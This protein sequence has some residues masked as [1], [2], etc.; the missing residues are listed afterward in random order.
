ML[1]IIRKFCVLSFLSIILGITFNSKAEEITHL[2]QKYIMDDFI[3][4]RDAET[5]RKLFLGNKATNYYLGYALPEFL[6]DPS[7]P[8]RTKVL[9][10]K[11]NNEFVG[12]ITYYKI[13]PKEAYFA[14]IVLDPKFR[15]K[16][17]AEWMINYAIKDVFNQGVTRIWFRARPDNPAIFLYKKLGFKETEKKDEKVIQKDGTVLIKPSVFFELVK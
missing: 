12:M 15:G 11:E 3:F 6:E 10:L 9:R 7:V 4:D 13:N 17:L 2:G 16:K 14:F 1:T 5:C 8:A